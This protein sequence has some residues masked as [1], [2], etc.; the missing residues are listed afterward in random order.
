M[1][2]LRSKLQR[3][4]QRLSEINLKCQKVSIQ[5]AKAA[6]LKTTLK[7]SI[8]FKNYWSSLSPSFKAIKPCRN[9]KLKSFF[10]RALYLSRQTRVQIHFS[11]CKCCVVRGWC[12][13][14]SAQV[15]RSRSVITEWWIF[16]CLCEV[17]SGLVGWFDINKTSVNWIIL[18]LKMDGF[19]VKSDLHL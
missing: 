5:S 2:Q 11:S 10:S 16:F 12:S 18:P 9:K 1:N 17:S 8:N 4:T 13:L 15:L 6:S 3:Q 14:T 19:A 7:K